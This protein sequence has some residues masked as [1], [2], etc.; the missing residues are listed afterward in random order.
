MIHI[1]TYTHKYAHTFFLSVLQYIKV[2]VQLQT[3]FPFMFF[4]VDCV[5][6]VKEDKCFILWV[7]YSR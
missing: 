7:S 1:Y 4:G 5:Q 2:K 3:S 6:N